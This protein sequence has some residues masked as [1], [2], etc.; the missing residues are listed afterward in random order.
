MVGS[1]LACCGMAT[2]LEPWFAFCWELEPWSAFRLIEQQSPSSS[3]TILIGLVDIKA[4]GE[5]A[6]HWQRRTRSSFFSFLR[7]DDIT[8]RNA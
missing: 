6:Q 2:R 1:N 7:C 5:L 8:S 4:L 3:L